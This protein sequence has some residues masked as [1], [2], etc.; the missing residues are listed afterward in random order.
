ME[1]YLSYGA[2]GLAA[3]IVIIA[4]RR[5]KD[6]GYQFYA[7]LGFGIVMLIIAAYFDGS[8]IKSSCASN[9]AAQLA[10]LTGQIA[11]VAYIIGN[12]KREINSTPPNVPN[13]MQNAFATDK[14]IEELRSAVA[15]IS[16]ELAQ[17]R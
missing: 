14:P 5:N 15:A 16:V 11:A 6:Q 17:C 4:A 12:I 3:I 9:A 13:A 1:K 10:P 2:L 8:R 7:F